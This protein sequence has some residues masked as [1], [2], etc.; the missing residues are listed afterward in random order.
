MCALKQLASLAKIKPTHIH[1]IFQTSNLTFFRPILYSN[2]GV[3]SVGVGLRVEPSQRWPWWP[4]TAAPHPLLHLSPASLTSFN[5]LSWAAAAVA[6]VAAT[7][8]PPFSVHVVVVAEVD[9]VV[10]SNSEAT[11]SWQRR[12]LE[13]LCQ[14]G[15]Y[16]QRCFA[17]QLNDEEK[18]VWL[19]LL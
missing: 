14:Q 1:Y 19:Y 11:P 15:Q 5:W 7:A 3:F 4:A 18:A 17:G 6:R 12:P 16:R 10:K 9:I 13:S 8:A 2:S